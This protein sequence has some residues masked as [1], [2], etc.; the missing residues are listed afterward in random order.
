MSILGKKKYVE[1]KQ[2][3]DKTGVR[4]RKYVPDKDGNKRTT[5]TADFDIAPDGSINTLTHD[6]DPEDIGD[7]TAHALR[8]AKVKKVTGDF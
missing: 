1:C 4:C 7:L 5:A 3:E 6:G 8:Y 2:K